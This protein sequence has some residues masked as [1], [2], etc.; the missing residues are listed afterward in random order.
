MGRAWSQRYHGWLNALRFADQ[1]AQLTFDDYLASVRA[2]GE[3][4]RRLDTALATCAADSPHRELLRALQAVRGIGFLSAV[5]I[6]AEAGDLRRFDGAARFMAYVGL[7]PSEHS[8]GASRR[9]GHITKA[10]NHLL[11]H[12]LG[13][14][15]HHARLQPRLSD[16]LRRRQEGVPDE[17]IRISWRCQQRLHHKYRHLGGRVGRNR[18]L[19]AV[20][21]EL[22]GFIW[23]I[24]QVLEVAAA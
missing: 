7:G 19:T 22:A 24:G 4:L 23:A 14:T 3:R 12:V 11:R 15:A 5:T 18:A 10:G 17:V 20:A 21:R 13:E 6:V 8:S 1:P 2:A 9:Q 16:G